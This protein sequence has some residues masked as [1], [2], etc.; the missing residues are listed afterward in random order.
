MKNRMHIIVA[1]ASA[2]VLAFALA[3]C[4]SSSSSSAASASASASAASASASA[5]SASAS[6]AAASSDSAAAA[7][8]DLDKAAFDALIAAGPVASDEDIAASTWATKVKEAG[9]LRVGGVQTSAL[10]SLLDATDN[11]TRG[12]DAGLYRMLA[13]YILGDDQAID[14]TLVQS[15]TR[16]SVLQS[17]QVDAVFATYSITPKRQELISFA[18]PYFVAHQGILVKSD[19]TTINGVDDLAG[20]TVGVQQGSTGPQ[21]V[22]EYAPQATVQELGTD[23]ELRT[24][25]EQGR[26][27]A[28]VVDS[29]LLMSSV[30]SN[31]GKYRIAGE[32]GPEDPYGI[33]L[34]L[35]SD[36]VAFVN[37]YLQKL[38]ADGTWAQLWQITIGDRTGTTAPE[39]PAIG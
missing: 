5:A 28:Y 33:G 7:S 1:I 30:V 38:V 39:A 11:Q 16:E 22:E 9:K 31:P 29:S 36:G 17:D 35:D 13:R 14:F 10:F 37:A 8:A 20:K 24:A 15:S 23:E 19:N 21:I 26:I 3:G 4:S 2:A 34:P 12:F 25:L 27:D 32:F 6:A 18:G